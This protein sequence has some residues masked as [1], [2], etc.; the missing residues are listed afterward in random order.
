MFLQTH[1]NSNFYTIF[2]ILI[3]LKSKPADDKIFFL[4]MIAQY[5]IIII[6]R[7]RRDFVFVKIFF[8]IMIAQYIIIIIC[9]KRRD[10]VFVK[11]KQF[12]YVFQLYQGYWIN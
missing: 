10:F 6:C 4:I 2:R 3:F 5:I 1:G 12:D 8:L 7:K 11:K 9:R